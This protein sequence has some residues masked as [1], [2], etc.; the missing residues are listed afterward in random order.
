MQSLSQYGQR[1]SRDSNR[2]HAIIATLTDNLDL[3]L[4]RQMDIKKILKER[5]K[6]RKTKE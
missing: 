5:K 2:A 1:P 4:Y 6:E 3:Y